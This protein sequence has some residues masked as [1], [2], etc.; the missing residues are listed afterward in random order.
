MEASNLSRLPVELRISIY[1]LL[2]ATEQD[3]RLVIE[4]ESSA[5]P[6]FIPSKASFSVN[7][8][9]SATCRQI[10]REVLGFV[11]SRHSIKIFTRHFQERNRYLEWTPAVLKT[12][13]TLES[14]SGGSVRDIVIDIGKWERGAH[15]HDAGVALSFLRRHLPAEVNIEAR[16][17]LGYRTSSRCLCIGHGGQHE[18]SIVIGNKQEAGKRCDEALEKLPEEAKALTTHSHYIAESWQISCKKMLEELVR[19]AHL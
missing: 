8:G 7:V 13:R 2:P 19:D 12:V 11:L 6:R 14:M 18:L 10:R 4:D 1:E 3:V 16:L 9:I 17:R 15:R 5:L